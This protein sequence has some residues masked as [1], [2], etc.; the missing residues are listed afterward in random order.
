MSTSRNPD[1]LR[2]IWRA[3]R[4]ITG[5][6]LREKYI[7][8]VELANKAAKLN[9]FEDAGEQWRS[10]YETDDFREQLEELWDK[11]RPLYEQ[12]HAYVRS[13]LRAQYGEENVPQRGPIPAHLLGE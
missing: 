12:L 11:L 8:F 7:R 9:G 6:P 13:R 4:D 1:E 3:W 5:K 10:E 2:Y